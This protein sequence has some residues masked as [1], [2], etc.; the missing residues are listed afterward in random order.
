M[1]SIL[2]KLLAVSAYVQALSVFLAFAIMV[3]LSY[4]FMSGIERKNLI[5]DVNAAIANTQ[6]NIE[7]ELAGPQIALGVISGSVRAMIVKGSDYSEVKDMLASCAGE[8]LSDEHL[9]SKITGVY[10][11]FNYNGEFWSSTQRPQR[12]FPPG[13]GSSWNDLAWYAAA[14]QAGGKV[15]VT[16][17][18]Y[19]NLLNDFCITYS[20]GI[21]ADNGRLLGVICLN[22]QLDNI[23][24]HAVNT[25]VTEASYGIL[26]DRDFNVIAHPHP[27]YAGRHI[28]QLNGGKKI[29][30]DLLSGIEIS[31]RQAVD[32]NGDASVLFVRRFNN[33]WHLAV[34]AYAKK[35]YQSVNDIAYILITLG[36]ILAS[37]LCAILMSTVAAKK[38][39]EERTRLLLDATP[40]CMILWNKNFIPIDCNEEALRLFNFSS[41]KEYCQRF[42][43]L[44]PE[45]Q[46][47]GKLS[48]DKS[49]EYLKKAFNDGYCSFEWT[50]RKLNGEQVPF[51]VK[52]IRVKF[53]KEYRVAAYMRDLQEMKDVMVK[54]RE[55]D[56]CTQVL[57]DA[58]PLSSFLINMK[59]VI[60]TCNQET[61]RL[62]G[63]SD[64]KEFINGFFNFFPKF[65][66]NGEISLNKV[67][68]FIDEAFEEGSSRF[69][70]THQHAS[71]ELIPTEVTMVR[72]K[73]RGEYALAGYIRDLREIKAMI[74]EMH[75]A[76]VA[77]ENNRAKSDFLAKMS[78][79][80]RTPMN[81]ILGIAEI[82]LQ[83]N[84]LTANVKEALGRIYSSGDMLLGIINDIL[85]L[86]K[87]EAGKLELTNAQYDVASLIHDTVQLN[88]MRYES[89]PI[90]FKL[91]VSESVPAVLIGDELRIKQILNNLLSNAFKYTQEGIVDMSVHI[92][93]EVRD[94][95]KA[96]TLIF[97]IN[98]TGQG[99][100]EEQ[101]QKLGEKFARFNLDINRA[102]E[103]TGLGMNITR[104][105]IYMMDG[106]FAIESKPGL[107]SNFT[108][109]IPQ[110][111]AGFEA[112]GKEWAKNLE[113]LNHGKNSKSR[114]AQITREYM[115][116]GS[117]LIVDDVETNLYVARGLLSPYGLSI[118][119]ALS[120]FEAIDRIRE[121][122][123]FDIIFM[124]HMMPKM[125]GVEAVKIIRELGYA[126]PIIALTANALTGQAEVFIKNGFDGFISKP[127]DIRQMNAVLNKMIR[128]K[129]PAEVIEEAR[130][131]KSS[132]T[133]TS[134]ELSVNPQL[135]EIFVRDAEK[136]IALLETINQN[137]C[138]RAD[139]I[140]MLIINVHAMKSA[141]ANIGEQQLSETAFKLETAGREQKTETI[142]SEIPVFLNELREVV[143]KY[144]AHSDSE[145]VE[146]VNENSE[147][148]RDILREK[149]I[150]LQAACA[151]YDKK[152]AKETLTEL[153]QI[154]WSPAIKERLNIISEYLL[155][156]DFEE[157]S[158]IAQ[159]LLPN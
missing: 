135:A 59:N 70:F 15:A 100:T 18:F 48:Y 24:E 111:D 10:G 76:Q 142:L 34:I 148:M 25:S 37:I 91:S 8:I 110:G 56:E 108:V 66:P 46:P 57:F 107:G 71:N 28:S 86:S 23:T 21:F 151:R 40:L 95:N 119:T 103:G 80:I 2:K 114:N 130:Q 12:G 131:K 82:Q 52:L 115:P 158:I 58:T 13:E 30:N 152:L 134:Q 121:G 74:A 16:E 84:S 3:F 87:I 156:S 149:L 154:Q 6:A 150:I 109:S 105:L 155:H 75:R 61:V 53:K 35:Y 125:D 122:K 117:V 132:M 44:S 5:N 42:F 60:V 97:R 137:K 38:K 31:E 159:D 92:E 29:E 54:M 65:Q 127:I 39:A 144:K 78:H 153:K 67:N 45:Y 145:D 138:R 113:Q 41:K 146:T 55:A 64:K 104:T 120:G 112:L 157:V 20:C 9:K 11:F 98:D 73:Y 128:D 141:L 118:D 126:N 139:D 101:V 116:Y 93:P 50:H 140:S 123:V 72:V 63:L 124:D 99:M 1:R 129:Q 27:G 83:D 143:D 133:E 49:L 32:Y 81:A 147:E 22:M 33:G 19:D 43:E 96:V 106:E 136:A 17:P 68:K 51:E 47:D 85:D 90:E 26:F 62:L 4:Y 79:E 77:E 14:A 89:K 102:T 88:I 69:E 94:E 36:V 7:A